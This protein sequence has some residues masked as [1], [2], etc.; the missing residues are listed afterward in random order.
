MRTLVSLLL[1]LVCQ[2]L[3]LAQADNKEPTLKWNLNKVDT[4]FYFVK[5]ANMPQFLYKD[6]NT[7]SKSFLR[8]VRERFEFPSDDCFG[9]M[10]FQFIVRPDST[11]ENVRLLK[12]LGGCPEYESEAVRIVSVM[13]KW[14]PGKMGDIPVKVLITMPISVDLYE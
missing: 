5:V 4:S 6:C 10:V 2:E 3:V 7:T 13:P 12:G 8:Y 9:K 11:I 14:T 1:L